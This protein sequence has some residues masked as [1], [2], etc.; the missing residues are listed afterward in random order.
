MPPAFQ[1]DFPDDNAKQEALLDLWNVN[2]NGF[3]AQGQL[4]DPWNAT[5]MDDITHYFNPAYTP[6]YDSAAIASIIWGALPGRVAFY[7]ADLSEDEQFSISDTGLKIDGSEP[8]PIPADP[9]NMD[10]GKT[11]VFGPYGPRGFQDEYSEWSVQKDAA[12]NITRIDFTCENPEYWNTLWM[13]DPD[14]ALD[15]YQSTLDYAT[16]TMDDLILK[17]ASGNPV[18]D[19]ST[20][21]PAY[22]P[23]NKF[24]SGS[25]GAM[26]LTSTPNTLQTE[27]GLA[28]SSTIQRTSG[29]A[30]EQTLICCGVFGQD[31]RNSDPHI[32][33][34]VN[35]VVEA[36]YKV[37]LTNPPGLY[38]QMPNFS[39]YKTPDG[40]DASEFWTIVRGKVTTENEYGVSLPGNY[41]L[42]AKFEVPADKGYTVS[43]ITIAGE[44]IKWGSQIA[45]TYNMQ[46]V[47]SAIPDAA[48]T[49]ED[50]AGNPASP[51]PDP[52]QL[53]HE[54]IFDAMHATEVP[55]PMKQYMNLLSNSTYI[56][57]KVTPGSQNVGMVLTTDQ[58]DLT[59]GDPQISFTDGGI[60]ASYVK[61]DTVSYAIPGNSYPSGSTA[62]YLS[63]NVGEDVAPGTYGVQLS[64]QGQTPG[65][66]MPAL[67]H[68]VES[69]NQ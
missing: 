46:I 4:G 43:D 67:L 2:L 63:V 23:L 61:S 27:I 64:A 25:G 36:G 57:P 48:P 69:I 56:A 26:H 19:P 50:C 45:A 53:F 3:T 24:N 42:H 6:G 9:C 5:N 68:V 32:G 12:G 33:G 8:P 22:N 54:S 44:P 59:T 65:P 31:F 41:I 21:R 39:Q 14:R 35:R 17:D 49:V 13:I 52:Q 51:T 62:L 40:T 16:I 58:I 18:I 11:M 34:S 20:G 30:N 7:F 38:I 15:I 29:N 66:A 10:N 28:T 60:T 55:N 47:A 37:T 1:M